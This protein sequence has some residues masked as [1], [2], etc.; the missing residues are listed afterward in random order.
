[1]LSVA[2][3]FGAERRASALW[4]R[5]RVHFMLFTTVIV[6]HQTVFIGTLIN[7]VLVALR[8]AMWMRLCKFFI[9]HHVVDFA[10]LACPIAY[11]PTRYMVGDVRGRNA[12]TVT[13]VLS[14]LP[15][16]VPVPLV[17]LVLLEA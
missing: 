6:A 7:S 11:F 17:D 9:L 16:H 4:R 13:L 8:S 2:G 15:L 3:D 14:N 12:S 10:H 1:M 5:L